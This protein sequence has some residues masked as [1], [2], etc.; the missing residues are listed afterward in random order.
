MFWENGFYDQNVKPRTYRQSLDELVLSALKSKKLSKKKLNSTKRQLLN[1]LEQN[2]LYIDDL[3]QTK[4][5]I[6]AILSSRDYKNWLVLQHIYEQQKQM[7][8]QKTN[9]VTDRI[10]SL[11]QPWVRPIVR[12]KAGKPTEFGA[13][14]NMSETQRYMFT[15]ITSITINTKKHRI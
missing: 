9:K 2:I 14:I 7:Y 13:Q 6:L 8:G 5:M 4:P 11:S 12:G 10:V 3:M 1:A 15:L